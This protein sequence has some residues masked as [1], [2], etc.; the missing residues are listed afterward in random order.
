M[1]NKNGLAKT[2]FS[3]A[4]LVVLA[5]AVNG[6]GGSSSGSAATT[7]AASESPQAGASKEAESAAQS[8][9]GEVRKVK[10]AFTNTAKPVSYIN[11][12]GEPDGYDVQVIKKIDELLPQYE[13]ELVPTNSEDAWMGV[14]SGKYQLCTTNSFKTPER[15]E[16]YLFADM[17]QGGSPEGLVV[18]KENADVVDLKTLAK[19]GLKLCPLRPADAI[20]SV[21]NTWNEENPDY[22]IGLEAIDQMEPADAIRFVAEGRYDAFPF[23]STGYEA[24]VVAEDGELHDL[25]DKL[26]F[27][28]FTAFKTY[29]LFNKEESLLRD[30][31][32][33]ALHQLKDDGT[34]KEL[35]EQYM[36]FDLFQYFEDDADNASEEA[37]ETSAGASA[38]TSAETSAAGASE[39]SSEADTAKQ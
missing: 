20:Y 18:R 16:K 13:F 25:N 12:K 15:E 17:N 2:L 26:A 35:S 33:K 6:C 21:I 31:Y 36:G 29:A 1:K 9:T 5:A 3:A 7:A 10:Y 39:G 19:S 37:A 30:D 38:E 14:E 4:A 11:E 8:G 34:L 23:Y 32:Q 22:Q 28:V 24:T 27:N